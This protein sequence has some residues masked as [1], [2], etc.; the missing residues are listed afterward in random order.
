MTIRRGFSRGGIKPPQRQIG[1]SAFKGTS[2]MTFGANL[3]ATSAGS[4]GS[5]LLAPAAT[6][7]RPLRPA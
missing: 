6:P 3:V 2:T 5:V 7:V 4:V 1:N